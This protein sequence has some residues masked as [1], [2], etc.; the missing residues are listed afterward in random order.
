MGCYIWYSEEGT[1]GLRIIRC[2]TIIGFGTPKGLTAVDIVLIT[3][4]KLFYTV[5][6]YHYFLSMYRTDWTIEG[7]DSDAS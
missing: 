6:K 5:T 1:G 4:S 2:T 7:L 3:V